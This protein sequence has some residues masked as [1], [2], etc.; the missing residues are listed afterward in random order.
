M[1]VISIEDIS[2]KDDRVSVVAV[3]EDT[4]LRCYATHLDPAEWEP[5]LCESSFY[6]YEDEQ[7][8]TDEEELLKYVNNLNLDWELVNDV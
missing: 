2:I 4:K 1:S 7:L 6:L 8:P 5:G 3:V